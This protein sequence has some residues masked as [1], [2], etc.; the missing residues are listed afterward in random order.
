MNMAKVYNSRWEAK[1]LIVN[2][3]QKQW[4]QDFAAFIRKKLF[5]DSTTMVTRSKAKT[6]GV[7]LIT[8]GIKMFEVYNG[9][10]GS[11]KVE[12]QNEN[13]ILYTTNPD[14]VNKYLEERK[15]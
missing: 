4:R 1:P 12:Y 9:Y 3:N 13:E 10:G 14:L 15:K 2:F 7:N 5:W 11:I 8:K 6:K